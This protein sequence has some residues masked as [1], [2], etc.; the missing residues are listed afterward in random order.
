MREKANKGK[1]G[2]FNLIFSRIFIFGMMILV[3]IILMT[4]MFFNVT[5]YSHFFNTL[6]Q[7]ISVL[8]VICIVSEQKTDPTTR[9]LWSILI[10]V[11]PVFG[12]LLYLYV[13]I[14]FG[15][16][17]IK[18]RIE[19]VYEITSGY[20]APD[21]EVFDTLKS[22]NEQVYA[23]SKYLYNYTGF[24]IY[25]GN[26][27]R[28]FS[29][30]TQKLESLLAD[31]KNAKSFI[32]LEYF[33]IEKGQV[34]NQILDALIE[35]QKEGVEIRV[36]YDGM[37]SLIQLPVGYYKELIK[38]GIQSKP[39]SPMRP[40]VTTSQNNRD[41]RKIIVIDGH[42][43][44]N[45]GINLADEYMNLKERFGY[46]KDT[47]V[48]IE[49]PA[50]K[51]F[52]LMFLRLWNIDS[53]KIEPFNKYLDF[54]IDTEKTN[55]NAGYV[56][57]FSDEPFDDENV[58]EQVYLHILNSAKKYVHII[59][60]YLVIDNLTMSALKFAAKRGVDVKLVL[61][62]IPDKK[63][64]YCVARTYYEEL[65]EAG[66]KIYEYTPGFTHAKMFISDDE[67]ATVGTINLDYRSLYLHFEC[68]TVVCQNPS[69]TEMENDFTQV[70]S[71]SKLVT[72]MECRNRSML[73][74]F[75][76]KL[77]R[78]IAPLL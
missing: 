37:C 32:F 28:Y 58:G 29:D 40:F 8:L 4:Q 67:I 30:G 38:L 64:A 33:I 27:V 51:S 11:T 76:G 22:D 47:A 70:I 5:G 2:L 20:L 62:G 6:I 73:Y 49:G 36:M 34:W 9:L 1:K 23:L 71:E 63:Y 13:K 60:P 55:A 19:E 3:Q 44:Y 56:A 61:P 78:L 45:G 77:L 65:I 66:V 50:A 12:T 59:T 14:Q 74:K 41:H 57:G 21:R 52:T 72:M 39:F 53:I 69:I 42:I 10:L 31:I 75:C 7:I 15:S 26:N 24:P 43:A 54:G 68:A 46:W 16:I 48:R 17:L 18:K 35:K 25:K